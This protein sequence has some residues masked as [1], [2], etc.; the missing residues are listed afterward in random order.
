MLFYDPIKLFRKSCEYNVRKFAPVLKKSIFK[1]FKFL[2][3][4]SHG[5]LHPSQ[6]RPRAHYHLQIR[7]NKIGDLFNSVSLLSVKQVCYNIAQS[8][9][10]N[11]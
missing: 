8:L 4:Y 1:I 5:F 9:Q 2:L 10:E 7:F 6:Y 11:K 3:L